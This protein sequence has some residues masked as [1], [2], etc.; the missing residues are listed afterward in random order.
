MG[1]QLELRSAEKRAIPER[2]GSDDSRRGAVSNVR[3]FTFTFT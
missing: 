1:V 2:F 3:T